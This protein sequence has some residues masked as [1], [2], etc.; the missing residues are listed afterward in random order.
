MWGVRCVSFLWHD[1]TYI[2]RIVDGGFSKWE[3]AIYHFLVRLNAISPSLGS[4]QTRFTHWPTSNLA[5]RSWRNSSNELLG[6]SQWG[7]I[8]SNKAIDLGEF[9][10]SQL[11]LAPKRRSN[12]LR[13]DQAGGRLWRCDFL[14]TN[15]SLDSSGFPYSPGAFPKQIGGSPLETCSLSRSDDRYPLQPGVQ[16]A[17]KSSGD[18]AR[19]MVHSGKAPIY[20][21]S[22]CKPSISWA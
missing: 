13:S 18:P 22:H 19:W 20:G 12:P 2:N 21:I 11:S 17:R 16:T 10:A 14:V 9:I 6:C 7:R 8:A 5:V 4:A 15:S 3:P 1:E